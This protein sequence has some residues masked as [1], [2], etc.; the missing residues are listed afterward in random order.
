MCRNASDGSTTERI[1]L[2]G[3]GY[4]D[5]NNCGKC[6]FCAGI[7]GFVCVCRVAVGRSAS[8]AG[9]LVASS[10]RNETFSKHGGKH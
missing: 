1:F 4:R 5:F 3:V 7:R 8:S 9:K 2:A 10:R 6:V